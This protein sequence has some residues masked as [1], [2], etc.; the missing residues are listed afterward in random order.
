MD[1]SPIPKQSGYI[2]PYNT[3]QIV[4]QGGKLQAMKDAFP[5]IAEEERP[6]S[7]ALRGV[8]GR[9]GP[10]ILTP[11]NP[12]TYFV[13]TSLATHFIISEALSGARSKDHRFSSP[14]ISIAYTIAQDVD[15]GRRIRFFRQKQKMILAA[16]IPGYFS[17]IESET[18]F[19]EEIE[20]H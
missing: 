3:S 14:V 4:R 5:D 6:G 17:T 1:L 10:Y 2:P 8:P 12:G 15:P 18:F 7:Y 16:D 11:V 20:F 19:V 9:K 13:L